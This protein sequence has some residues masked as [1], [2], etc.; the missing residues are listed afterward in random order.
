MTITRTTITRMP[1]IAQIHIEAII[2]PI[3][4]CIAHLISSP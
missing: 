3:M 2:P 4:P 1:T